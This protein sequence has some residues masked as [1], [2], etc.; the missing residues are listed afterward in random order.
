M[1]VLKEYSLLYV[2]ESKNE[3]LLKQVEFH[4][5]IKQKTVYVSKERVVHIQ[6]VTQ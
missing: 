2:A 3:Y 1:I 5:K 6:K 4:D